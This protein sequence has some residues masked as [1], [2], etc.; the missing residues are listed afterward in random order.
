MVGKVELTADEQSLVDRI[1]FDHDG[2]VALEREAWMMNGEMAANLFESLSER[3]A[4]PEV[5]LRYFADPE[6]N[7]SNSK[8]SHFELFLRNARTRA[9][10]LRHAH[11]IPYLRYFVFGA[12][13]PA[14][15]KQ[16]F[17]AEFQDYD[18]D[19]E[20]LVRLARTLYREL[21]RT[22]HPQDY[23]LPEDFYQL[24]LD[25]GCARW[26]AKRIRDAVKVIK[27]K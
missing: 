10:V 17:L 6:Y 11:F 21:K 12:N 14:H 25:C 27:V 13:L 8:A 23:P 3:Q 15:V 20:R 2:I 26:D 5:R 4:I 24:A 1:V 19:L 18:G 7:P 16:T 9:E 22:P